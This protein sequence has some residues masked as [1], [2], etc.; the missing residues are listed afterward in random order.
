MRKLTKICNLSTVYKAWIDA[1]EAVPIAH[2]EYN[3]S[4]HKFYWDIVMNLFH[5]QAGLCAYTEMLLCAPDLYSTDKWID[6]KYDLSN[7]KPQIMG[8]LEHFDRSLKKKKGWLWDNFF[9]A[10]T[11]INTKVKL[12]NAAPRILRPDLVT[13]NEFNLLEY[14]LDKHIF[15]PNSS[16]SESDQAIVFEDILI[17][18]INFGPISEHRRVY[19]RDKLTLIQLGV[20]KWEEISI[21]QFPTALQ[22]IRNNTN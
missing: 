2:P 4:S 1:F 9:M 6:G 22:M 15:L 14:D 8:Q 16:L 18:G 5:C 10:N 13:Y 7:G 12:V 11:D 17:L 20:Q 3:S 19:I 21:N